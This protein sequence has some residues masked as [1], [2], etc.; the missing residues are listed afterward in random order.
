MIEPNGSTLP[1]SCCYYGSYEHH[2]V[3][4]WIHRA[5]SRPALCQGPGVLR[6]IRH[7]ACPKN[8][9]S[10]RG[11]HRLIIT[12]QHVCIFR[13]GCHGIPGQD[14]FITMSIKQGVPE[15]PASHE[16]VCLWFPVRNQQHN[17]GEL[18]MSEQNFICNSHCLHYT[19]FITTSRSQEAWRRQSL[20]DCVGLLCPMS[21]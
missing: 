4:I 16:S 19:W 20:S 21:N 17:R 12:K 18:W 1:S 3:L 13:T 8:L 14:S 10:L 6:W 9:Q 2:T 11:I 5:Q 15:N 7:E